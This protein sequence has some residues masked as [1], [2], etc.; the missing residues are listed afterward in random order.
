M[1]KSILVVDDDKINLKITQMNL[2]QYGYKV[3]TMG[4]GM[5][6]LNFLKE[7]KVDLILM[8]IEMPIM[9][10]MRTLELIRKRADTATIPV[11]FLTASAEKDSVVEACRL[12]A[13]DY[14]VKPFVPRELYIRIE[15]V[16]GGK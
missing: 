6:A 1:Q 10:G 2:S 12:E 9:N 5:E 7:Q 14:V 8:D 3:Y 16:L 11:I 13:V 4:S 15:R